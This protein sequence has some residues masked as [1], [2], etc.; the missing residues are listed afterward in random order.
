[1]D[2]T[3]RLTK[4]PD[5][6]DIEEVR[7]ECDKFFKIHNL[8]EN[9]SHSLVMIIS[10]LMENCI[11][12]GDFSIQ[13][14]QIEISVNLH[15]SSVVIELINPVSGNNEI[16]LKKL[17]RTIQW[18][19]GYQDPFEAF[20]ERIR[21]VSKKG[22]HDMESGLGLVRIAYEGKAVLDFYVDENNLLNVSAIVDIA[23]N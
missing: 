14:S 2:R 6:D 10:E 4:N 7:I 18:I 21:K 13:N 15:G 16:D 9:D 8:S 11:K 23:N 19:R 17:D 5:W 22:L 3:I 1:M 12:Y 20:I